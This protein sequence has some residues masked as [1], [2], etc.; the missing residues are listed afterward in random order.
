MSRPTRDVL[1][2][3]LRSA[4]PPRTAAQVR[5]FGGEKRRVGASLPGELVEAFREACEVEERSQ[6]EVLEEL[7]RNYVLRHGAQTA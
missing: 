4:P 6:R 2:Q 3:L 7:V 1:S 5:R